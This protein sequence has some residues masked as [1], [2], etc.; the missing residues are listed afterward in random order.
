MQASKAS[1]IMRLFRS[2]Y[3]AHVYWG[4]AVR[5]W[6]VARVFPRLNR[7]FSPN[8]N[9]SDRTFSLDTLP[10]E[11]PACGNTDFRAPAYQVQLE[12][13]STVTDSCHTTHH[14]YKIN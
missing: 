6:H 9:P 8:P 1:Y 11:Y 12:N 7:A 13:G 4:K 2:G 5:D 3:L 10:Q 14:I